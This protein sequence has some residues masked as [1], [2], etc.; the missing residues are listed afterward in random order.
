MREEKLTGMMSL[1]LELANT[2]WTTNEWI[3]W[4]LRNNAG[5]IVEDGKVTGYVLK[6]KRYHK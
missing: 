4:C 6:E 1:D 3:R 5:I 2:Q